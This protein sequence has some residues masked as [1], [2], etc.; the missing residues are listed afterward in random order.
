MSKTALIGR[1]VEQKILYE[2]LASDEA[3]MV[4]VI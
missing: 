3:E 4:A 2:A 1:A